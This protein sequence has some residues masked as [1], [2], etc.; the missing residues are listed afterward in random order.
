MSTTLTDLGDVTLQ[1]VVKSLIIIKNPNTMN[2]KN[3]KSHIWKIV[4]H[5]LKIEP[6]P[7]GIANTETEESNELMF[8]IPKK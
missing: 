3:A 4:I 7:K 5:E 1:A 8:F 6:K 2:L